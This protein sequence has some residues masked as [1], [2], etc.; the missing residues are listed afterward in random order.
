MNHRLLRS[1]FAVS[2]FTLV[3]LMAMLTQAHAVFAGDNY[4]RLTH[5]DSVVCELN[6]V[7]HVLKV[8]PVNGLVE[9]IST[10]GFTIQQYDFLNGAFH[11]SGSEDFPAGVSGS[12]ANGYFTYSNILNYPVDMITQ[13]VA[14]VNGQP[15]YISQF[16]LHCDADGAGTIVV[17][18][19]PIGGIPALCINNVPASAVQGVLLET[20]PAYYAPSTDATTNITLPVGSHWWIMTTQDGFTELMIAC[21]ANPVWVDSTV[22]GTN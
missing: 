18:N 5:A 22:I 8:T 1:L 7:N 20:A 14:F 2:L 6:T 3:G 21:Q 9:Y 12:A 13:L 16:H 19:S 10:D 4:Y 15:V 11:S 17:Q